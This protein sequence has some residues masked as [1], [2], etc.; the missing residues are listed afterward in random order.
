MFRSFLTILTALV[1]TLILAPF[2]IAIALVNSHAPLVDWLIR[3][4]GGLL[5]GASGIDLSAEGVEKLDPSK[6]YVLVPNHSSYLD[7]PCLLTALDT[8]PIRFMAKASLF[9][10]PILGWGM[11]AAGF[12]PID[13]KRTSKGKASFDLAAK[14]IRG[15]NTIVIFPEG[16]RARERA[17]KPFKHGAFLLAMKS[18]LPLVPVAIRGTFDA[19]PA[20]TLRIR[21]GPVTIVVGD[22][23]DV[24]E[25]SVKQKDELVQSTRTAILA[26]LEP[27]SAP[28][29]G[30]E[31]QRM[32]NAER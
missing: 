31:T 6:R 3:L 29:P 20:S 4:W 1:S 24:S 17:M 32:Q 7:I 18:G 27:E 25:L 12:I 2:V 30:D 14:R 19:L 28:Q 5:V 21:R 26:M 10:I 11:L 13:R 23:V 9:K 22:P 8:Q 16:S 15:G